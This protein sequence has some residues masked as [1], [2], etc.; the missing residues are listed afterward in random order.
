MDGKRVPQEVAILPALN[1]PNIIK[2]LDYYEDAKYCY[3]ITELHGTEWTVQNP[4]LH[5]STHPG[6]RRVQNIK[7]DGNSLL[8]F[9]PQVDLRTMNKER[10]GKIMLNEEISNELLAKQRSA[11]DLFEC[12]DIHFSFTESTARHIF[13]QIA[14]AMAY[15]H[16][17]GLVHRDLKARNHLCLHCRRVSK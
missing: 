10:R 9:V 14:S 5:P 17:E 1:H 7:N 12:I 13:R 2:F 11:C 3:L 16:G 4:K 6:L 15:L 8:T